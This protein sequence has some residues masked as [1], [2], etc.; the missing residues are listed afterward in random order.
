MSGQTL[1]AV[2]NDLMLTWVTRRFLTSRS[3]STDFGPPEAPHLPLSLLQRLYRPIPLRA[4]PSRSLI[5]LRYAESSLSMPIGCRPRQPLFI[6]GQ[7]SRLVSQTRGQDRRDPRQPLTW[8]S[9]TADAIV[10]PPFIQ[11]RSRT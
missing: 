3:I 9:R 7:M 2:R 4:R 11:L 8:R 5:M 1:S 10:S 6:S